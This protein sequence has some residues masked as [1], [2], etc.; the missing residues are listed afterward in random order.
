MITSDVFV[1]F[2]YSEK[3]PILDTGLT[4]AKEGVRL[5][6]YRKDKSNVVLR[7]LLQRVG[8]YRDRVRCAFPHQRLSVFVLKRHQVL[9]R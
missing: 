7:G 6:L 8:L 4:A 2:R 9:D 5:A 1:S 3:P